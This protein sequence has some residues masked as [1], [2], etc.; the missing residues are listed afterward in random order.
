MDAIAR[1]CQQKFH[2]DPTSGPYFI[3]RNKRKTDIKL[4]YYDGQG[5]C[6]MQKRLSTGRFN[7]WPT[8]PHELISLTPIQIQVLIENGDPGSVNT[9][10]PWK[11][12]DAM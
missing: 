5:Q 1:L 11:P 12:M 4:L 8:N 6:L 3:F 2:Q 10:V 9:A 7:Y